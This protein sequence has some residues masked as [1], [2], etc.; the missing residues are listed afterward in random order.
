MNENPKTISKV[1]AIKL[2]HEAMCTINSIRYDNTLQAKDEE[3]FWNLV[4]KIPQD[5]RESVIF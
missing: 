4:K 1:E 3:S 5:M 2:L